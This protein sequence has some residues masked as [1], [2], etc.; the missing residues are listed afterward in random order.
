MR[1]RIAAYRSWANTRDPAERMKPAQQAFMDRFE[2]EVDPEGVLPVHERIRR[3]EAAKKA[4][5]TEL[6]YK[7]VRSRRL[8]KLRAERGA[9]DVTTGSG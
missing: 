6:S 8:A 9:A 2:R 7:A 3:A 1:A 5:F 4:Y